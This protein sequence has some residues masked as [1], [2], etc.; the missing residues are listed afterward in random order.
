MDAAN[1]SLWTVLPGYVQQ[2]SVKWLLEF[3]L[4]ISMTLQ[5]LLVVLGERRYQCSGAVFRFVV[6][7]SYVSADA[8]AISALGSMMHS[9]G[10]SGIYG[11]WAPLLL[12]HLGGP[13]P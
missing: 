6:W 11:L 2:I 13:M 5:L 9:C 7:G 10:R 12:L 3:L 4:L 1:H 8:L